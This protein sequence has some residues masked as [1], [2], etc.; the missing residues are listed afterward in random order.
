MSVT[1]ER[2]T[3]P[4]PKWRRLPEERPH[5]IMDAA[6]EVFGERGLAGARLEDVAKRAGVSKGTIYLYF[7]NKLALFQ[8]MIRQT[9]GAQID[10]VEQELAQHQGTAAEQVDAYIHAW[11][12]FN[13]SPRVQTIARLLVGELHRFPELGQFY[14]DEVV[15]RK[16]QVLSKLI[17]RGV[18][19]G[20]FRP[21]EPEPTARLLGA[22]MFS[23]ASWCGMRALIPALQRFSDDEIREQIRDFF[24]HA[25]APVN[26]P[27]PT[28]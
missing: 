16:V 19:S 1:A 14:A 20:Q 6:V 5:Q 8:E 12:Q 9:I 28:K 11:W 10:R 3:T 24:F 18:E 2:T 25:I 4:E 27:A 13:L 23:Y 22:M 15:V 7:P 26:A 21:V 17:A